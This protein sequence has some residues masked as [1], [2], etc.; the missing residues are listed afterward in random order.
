MFTHDFIIIFDK[1][2]DL[3]YT[4]IVNVDYLEHLIQKNQF[5]FLK[6]SVLGKTIQINRKQRDIQLIT[7]ERTRNRQRE[8]HIYQIFAKYLRWKIVKN[9]FA[10]I[11]W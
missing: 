8:V 5:N 2:S 10:Y 9:E 7:Y 4:E 11:C 6:N 3:G 1:I